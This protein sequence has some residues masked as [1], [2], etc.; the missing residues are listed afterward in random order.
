MVTLD[1]PVALVLSIFAALAAIFNIYYTIVKD[2]PKIAI[3][4]QSAK[5]SWRLEDADVIY[6]FV[7][8]TGGK[9]I[10]V[11]FPDILLPDGKKLYLT[12]EFSV[13]WRKRGLEPSLAAGA[14]R[15]PRTYFQDRGK[16]GVTPAFPRTLTP[17]AL[18]EVWIRTA[19]L[20]TKLKELRYA[21][22]EVTLKVSVP[23]ASQKP[24]LSVDEIIFDVDKEEWRL[25]TPKK[26]IWDEIKSRI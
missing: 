7:T 19:D 26:S 12:P 22:G 14:Q 23:D 20:A 1:N 24:H 25:L 21:N 10:A 13:D 2:R 5:V 15:V 11:L 4:F 17:G 3:K 6:I 9:P 8:N 16:W 18:N